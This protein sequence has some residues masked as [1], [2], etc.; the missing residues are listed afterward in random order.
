MFL[1]PKELLNTNR[2]APAAVA[3]KPANRQAHRACI[4][5]TW[6]DTHTR[7]VWPSLPHIAKWG[8][9]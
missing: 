3:P 9:I 1:V 6:L 2:Q 4:F 8:P 5:P 7:G